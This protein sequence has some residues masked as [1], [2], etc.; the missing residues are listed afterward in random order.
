MGWLPAIS[1][2]PVV[3]I[4]AALVPTENGDGEILLFGGDDHDRAANIAGQWDHSRRFNCR[5]PLQALVYVKS[6]NADLFCCG[7]AFLGDGQLLTA[8]GTTTFPPQSGG[9]HAH[10]HFEGHRHAFA[11]SPATMV[12]SEV[13]SMGFEPGTNRGGGRWYPTLCTLPTGQVL[14]IGG[15]PSGLDTRH[16]NNRPERYEA[17]L[18][19]WIMLAPTG[20]DE[21]QGPDVY[22]RLHVLGDGSVFVSSALQGNPRCIII[23]PETGAKREICDLPD[24]AYR[25]IGCPAVLLP[26]TLRDNY[27]ARVLLC[28]GRTSQVIDLGDA[29]P[30]WITVPRKGATAGLARNNACATLLPTG[31]V[32]MT[33][34]ADPNNDQAGVMAPELYSS[35]IDR[36]A[37]M[38]SYIANPGSWNTL[39]DP[40]TVLRNYHSTA[41][42]MPNAQVWTGGGNSPTQPDTP[43]GPNQEKIEIFE[44]PYTLGARPIISS[45]PSFIAYG[46][47]FTI[48]VPNAQI[49]GWV[50]LMRCGS[51]THAFNPDQRAVWLQFRVVANNSLFALAPPHGGVAPPGSYMLFVIDREG[52]PCQYAGFVHL[53]QLPK[54]S[55]RTNSGLLIQ[56]SFGAKGNFELVIPLAEGGLG[57][58]W[59]DND[60]DGN[61]W[62]DSPAEVFGQGIFDSVSLIQSNFSASGNGRGNLE[63]IARAGNRLVGFYKPDDS[64]QWLSA[65]APSFGGVTGNPALIQ[66]RFGKGRGNFELIVP[67]AGG[68]L[69]HFWRDNDADGNPWSDSPAEV[70]GQGIFDSVSLIQSNF[71]ASGNGRGNLEVIARAGNRLVGFYK[72]DD[73]PQWLSASAPSFGGVTGNPA[74]IQSRF[75][76][77][78]G[79]FE[80]IVPLA[81]GG[82]GHFWRD[83]DADGNPWSDSP[84]EVFG[85]GMFDSV[86]LIQSNFSAS[87]NGHGNLEVIARAGNRSAGFY[88]PDD[89]A[90]WL[91]ASSPGGMRNVPDLTSVQGDTKAALVDA[92]R[93]RLESRG[94]R[95]GTVTGPGGRSLI[96]T[97]QQPNAGE[98]VAEG[99]AVNIEI[100]PLP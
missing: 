60:A 75:G 58:L 84:A 100:A 48:G 3:A 82:L 38:P 57:H 37:G 23:D 40:A 18:N 69:G 5:H 16:N 96:I 95:L 61:P 22:P 59:R 79:N 28:G 29:S 98:L 9:I 56:S 34:G 14:A 39:N 67:L 47:E 99:T 70:F 32:L 65:S 41:L 49:I 64:P 54:A 12:F 80:L 6:P 15:H 26:L 19:R 1:S 4:H 73:S 63:V 7:H 55:P 35:P 51:S 97:N 62:S 24:D 81:G 91:P 44:P 90:Q 10:I 92:A 85:Q 21:V 88:K 53:A 76:K 43:P 89:S 25:G 77:G 83:N 50:V 42:L 20:P 36:A 8:G 66:S 46:D 78:R 72:P 31:D 17:Q 27:R 13:A 94:L 71:S 87:G 86:S 30:G 11:Y 74:L 52:R 45:C 93:E 68:G 33:G 2:D